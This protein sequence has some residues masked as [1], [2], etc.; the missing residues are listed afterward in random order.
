MYIQHEDKYGQSPEDYAET[1]AKRLS[2]EH[3]HLS[4]FLEKLSRMDHGADL[5]LAQ[6][7]KKKS[8]M[9]IDE[10]RDVF[11]KFEYGD[12]RREASNF[13]TIRLSGI[14]LNCRTD[15][16]MSYRSTNRLYKYDVE[17]MECPSMAKMAK[18]IRG[19]VQAIDE[20]FTSMGNKKL[21][22][23]RLLEILGEDRA[24]AGY[25]EVVGVRSGN[26]DAVYLKIVGPERAVAK[27]K[28][29]VNE[30]NVLV[31]LDAW[32]KVVEAMK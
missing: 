25:G 10:T 15:Y 2:L 26:D 31:V 20:F 32:E 23:E 12:Y 16:R 11:L 5:K 4:V 28:L 7:S 30:R 18:A 1:L 8:W 22:K 9:I 14:R 24:F 21:F 19:H 17:K 3:E 29:E 6:S 27:V 13:V